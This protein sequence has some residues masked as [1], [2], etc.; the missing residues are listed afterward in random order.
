[1]AKRKSFSHVF[2]GVK[3]KIKFVSPEELEKHF[4][5]CDGLCEEPKTPNPKIY[6]NNSV[7]PMR[8]IQILVHE[9]T[10]SELFYTLSEKTVTRIGEEIGS[11]LWKLGYR[12]VEP[13]E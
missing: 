6:L 5:G 3:Y 2:N 9:L 12:K 10:H 8:A 13:E 4:K 11:C 1:M 7:D